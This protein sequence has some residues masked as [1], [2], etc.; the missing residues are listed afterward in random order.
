MKEHANDNPF[1]RGI[2][3]LI[4][5]STDGW[6]EAAMWEMEMMDKPRDDWDLKER[7]LFL[8]DDISDLFYILGYLLGE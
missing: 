1:Y 6:N 5:W 4:P 2:K 7:G 3:G 8:V